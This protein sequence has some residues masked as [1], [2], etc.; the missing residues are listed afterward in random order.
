MH[1][2]SAYSETDL[3]L[4]QLTIVHQQDAPPCTIWSLIPRHDN[5]SITST[6]WHH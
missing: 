3:P 6:P 4:L 1:S 5:T 2:R